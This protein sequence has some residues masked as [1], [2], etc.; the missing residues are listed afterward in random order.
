MVSDASTYAQG[1]LLANEFADSPARQILWID[2]LSW[3]RVA[4]DNLVK[5]HIEARYRVYE[6]GIYLLFY[7]SDSGF[8]LSLRITRGNFFPWTCP[9][10][11]SDTSDKRLSDVS[12]M[13]SVIEAFCR[14][15][16]F[17]FD[18]AFSDFDARSLTILPVESLPELARFWR[19][20]RD[21]EEGG[22]TGLV[23]GGD[24]SMVAR[25]S[26]VR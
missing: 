6:C 23:G 3:Y 20:R 22:M 4:H 18:S 7:D 15:S 21:I 14:S 19:P 24:E 13:I 16:L 17:D 8:G 9:F 10:D 2:Q 1:V 5:V 26:S 12:P 25:T 11:F